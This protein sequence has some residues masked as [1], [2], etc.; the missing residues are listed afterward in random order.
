MPKPTVHALPQ[1]YLDVRAALDGHSLLDAAKAL[2][3]ATADVLYS[4]HAQN[5]PGT[6]GKVTEVFADTLV[7][8]LASYGNGRGGEA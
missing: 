4:V 1:A 2:A 3:A 5:P 8:A 6:V 7:V